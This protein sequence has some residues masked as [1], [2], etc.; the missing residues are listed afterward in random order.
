MKYNRG[1]VLSALRE[2]RGEENDVSSLHSSF[3]EE[4]ETPQQSPLQS[5]GTTTKLAD[6]SSSAPAQ[7]NHQSQDLAAGPASPNN[8]PLAS[9]L[10]KTQR[11]TW[12]KP[13]PGTA[14]SSARQ[15]LLVRRSLLLGSLETPVIQILHNALGNPP[16]IHF[17][18]LPLSRRPHPAPPLTPTWALPAPPTLA[19]RPPLP[20][21]PTWTDSPTPPTLP[22]TPH[23]L[24]PPPPASPRRH[25][26]RRPPSGPRPALTTPLPPSLHRPTPD[27]PRAGPSASPSAHHPQ[28]PTPPLPLTQRDRQLPPRPGPSQAELPV[29]PSQ[30]T[31]IARARPLRTRRRPCPLPSVGS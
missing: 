21:S 29:T 17:P 10:G 13:D 12:S 1:A 24:S 6:S 4:E 19:P 23:P 30:R 22:L 8:R 25:P 2:L 26:A 11:M 28:H 20:P 18:V 16:G 7:E 9:P 5:P 14:N 15:A 31:R 3:Y 27:G